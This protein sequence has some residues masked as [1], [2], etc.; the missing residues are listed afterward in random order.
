[1]DV[2]QNNENVAQRQDQLLMMLERLLELPAIEVDTTLKQTS[3]MVAEV[4][5]A[6][7]VDIF[8]YEAA[9]E[10]LVAL[11]TSDTPMGRRQH[12]IGMDRLPLANG[13]RVVEV[14]LSGN[15]YFTGHA[16]QDSDE[17]VGI[18]VGLGVK[19]QMGTV[20]QVRAQHQ[21]VLLVASGTSDYF[22]QQDLRFLE[23]V[24]RW[25]GIVI[26]RA[27]IVEQMRH[28]A[29]EQGRRLAAEELLTIM[30]HDL[31]NYLTPM[32]GRI[33]MLE[34][35]ARR[36]GREQDIRD[37]KAT[38]H[39]LS[40]LERVITDLLDVARLNEGI[41]VITPASMNLV[42]LIR[43]VVVAFEAAERPIYV[44]APAEVVLSVDPARLR[45]LLENLL[46]NAVTYAPRQTPVTV[47]VHIDRRA[48]GPWVIL[49]VS[50]EGP[51]L[52]PERLAALV[53]PFIAGSQS[54]GLG[55][56]L[57]LVKRITEAHG[58]TLTLESPGGHG[59]QATIALPV[60][61]E[62]LI[63]GDQE[64]SS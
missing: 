54:I 10:T 30:A 1:M 40:L 21:G 6:D 61:E 38:L 52:P 48:D 12:A 57:Y 31:R 49:T 42:H 18:K 9:N 27:Q 29:V 36:D 22:S 34:R 15:S 13:G 11:G 8:F 17:L 7:K 16:D 24:A 62:E 44:H 3:Q 5:A 60:E 50:N 59:V 45:Q 55:L 37:T 51:G 23:A 35:R 43:E 32:K 4:L 14:F 19:S 26:D 63:V 53:H 39:T 41:F 25:I 33:E 58:G 64:A 20:F 47:E 46:A 28:E 56:G 2:V